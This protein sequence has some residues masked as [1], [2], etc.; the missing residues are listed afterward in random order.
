MT[1]FA[2]SAEQSQIC[3]ELNCNILILWRTRFNVTDQ[4]SWQR[5]GLGS[6]KTSTRL[7]CQKDLAGT[8]LPVHRLHL[9]TEY[10]VLSE[11]RPLDFSG[12]LRVDANDPTP[13]LRQNAEQEQTFR[14]PHW[15]RLAGFLQ[16]LDARRSDVQKVEINPLLIRPSDLTAQ[17]IDVEIMGGVQISDCKS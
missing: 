12:N 15:S 9:G 2:L 14:L 5:V 1:I 7:H 3:N 10:R 11:T 4:I 8:L 6:G 17:T 16:V 13:R